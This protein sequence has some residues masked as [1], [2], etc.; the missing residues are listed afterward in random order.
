MADFAPRVVPLDR[1]TPQQKAF[2]RAVVETDSH[3]ILEALAGTG[4]TS[5][6]V[7]AA[8]QLIENGTAP[9]DIAFCAFNTHIKEEL[10]RKI[11]PG[12]QVLTTHQLGLRA[13]AAGIGA[14]PKIESN[15]I[16]ILLEEME[17]EGALPQVASQSKNQFF[18]LVRKLVGLCKNTL[19][20]PCEAGKPQEIRAEK[21]RELALAYEVNICPAAAKTAKTNPHATELQRDADARQD[22][23][24][25]S[26]LFTVVAG[27]FERSLDLTSI[28]DFD[29]MLYLPCRFGWAPPATPI[30]F[31]DEVQD[32][33][34]AQQ[35][36]V[37]M[38]TVDCGG[39]FIGVGDTHQA[40]Y[41]FRGA[42][43]DAMNRLYRA[44]QKSDRGVERLPL[45]LSFRCPQI[46]TRLAQSIV[47]DF[48]CLPDARGGRAVECDFETATAHIQKEDLVICRLNAPLVSMAFRLLRAGKPVVFKGDDLGEQ[49]RGFL[50]SF[51]EKDGEKLRAAIRAHKTK[52]M[53]SMEREGKTEN[54]IAAFVDKCDCALAL[55]EGAANL[56][57]IEA[58]LQ[59]IFGSKTHKGDGVILHTV[60][61]SK[62]L[63][64]RRVFIIAPE[65][66]PLSFVKS[67]A[68]KRQEWNLRYV[69]LT[70]TLDELWFVS[71]DGPPSVQELRGAAP[72]IATPQQPQLFEAQPLA[73]PI[74][75]P[76]SEPEN[77]S[78][79]E[80]VPSPEILVDWR[81]KVVAQIKIA[82][83]ALPFDATSEYDALQDALYA[84][85]GK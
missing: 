20:L 5:S 65:T 21:L 29:D 33:N 84:V 24:F 59:A 58:N 39:R 28:V 35:K 76:E 14:Q 38:A 2:W 81:A 6:I 69:A 26:Q 53:L 75:E 9:R 31:G 22:A 3:L 52:E 13:I 73:Q 49:A 63:E 15:K 68:G 83:D 18:A 17:L 79:T 64:A 80:S 8:A 16:W 10:A 41:A 11:P 37:W 36:L 42:D 51:K 70:R 71:K 30:L 45:T 7:S 23:L 34:L 78:E 62:G 72:C 85:A 44:L 43:N 56:E 40:I 19:T 77:T 61:G 50:K 66:M 67:E 57:E 74:A 82:M 54:Q 60:H 1:S 48:E 4:K 25:Q 32:W 46:A 12:T 55:C 47:S 27:V